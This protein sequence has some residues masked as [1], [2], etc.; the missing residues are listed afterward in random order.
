MPSKHQIFSL[1]EVRGNMALFRVTMHRITVQAASYQME[2]DEDEIR[3]DEDLPT[4]FFVE[5]MP[6]D[7]KWKDVN[8]KKAYFHQAQQ[9]D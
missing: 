4:Q 3:S 2:I 8:P 6:K 1:N 7:I 9:E 5:H